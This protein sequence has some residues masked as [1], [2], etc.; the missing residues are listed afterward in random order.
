MDDPELQ[1]KYLE[2]FYRTLDR[3]HKE[4]QSNCQASLQNP[5]HPINV[6]IEKRYKTILRANLGLMGVLLGILAYKHRDRFFGP[7]KVEQLN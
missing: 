4:Y 1:R 2:R 5:N 6:K 3:R 7:N